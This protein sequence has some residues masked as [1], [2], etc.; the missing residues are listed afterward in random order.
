MP[1]GGRFGPGPVPKK[2]SSHL[3]KLCQICDFGRRLPVFHKDFLSFL[4]AGILYPEDIQAMCPRGTVADCFLVPPADGL[5]VQS[6]C[7]KKTRA[8]LG[9]LLGESVA[10]HSLH[11]NRFSIFLEKY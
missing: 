11:N 7:D 8:V 9:S 6:Y 3:T 1:Q 2:S 10:S 5:V 4:C